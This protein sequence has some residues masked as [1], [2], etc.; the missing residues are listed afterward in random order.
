MANKFNAAQ[1]N[2]IRQDNRQTE[3]QGVD[4]SMVTVLEDVFAAIDSAAIGI[5]ASAADI[6]SLALG[7]GTFGQDSDTTTG[8]TFG[9]K[10]G[11][12]IN[13]LALVDFSA[14]TLILSESTTNYVEVNRAGVVSSNTSGFTSGAF[15]LYVM[16]TGSASIS[17]V[18]NK[19]TLLSLLGTAGVVGSMLSTMGATKEQNATLGDLLATASFTVIVPGNAGTI[20][21]ISLATRTA[22]ATSDTDYWKFKVIN[23]GVEGSGTTVVVDD[24]AAANSTKA[25]GGAAITGYVKRDLTL[26]R[27]GADLI[28]AAGDMLEITITKTGSATT[29]AQCALRVDSTFT[30]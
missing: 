5:T 23:K 19:K 24:T 10:A 8:L 1:A 6:D 27:T 20:S 17:A 4:T 9:Y 28:F 25:T 13:G 11:R 29:M 30:G 26:T 7:A 2:A 12:F 18:T 14:G 3:A 22:I 16:A 21:K 15:P